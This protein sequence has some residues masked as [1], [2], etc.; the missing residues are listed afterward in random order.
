MKKIRIEDIRR[1]EAKNNLNPIVI[2]LQVVGSGG[3]LKFLPIYIFQ[4]FH[5]INRF[6]LQNS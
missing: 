1:L 6:Q 5:K 2:K 4:S 3:T